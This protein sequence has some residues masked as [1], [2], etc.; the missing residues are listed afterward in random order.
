VTKYTV[1]G[2]G[3]LYVERLRTMVLAELDGVEM[4][5]D[6]SAAG[7]RMQVVGAGGVAILPMRGLVV[8]LLG[9]RSQQDVQVSDAAW[10]AATALVNWFP[11]AHL[12]AQLMGRLQMPSGTGEVARTLFLQLHYYL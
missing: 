9:E 4:V 7:A 10:T 1:G 2:V 12:E 8:T 5:F 6:D 11:M 3:K